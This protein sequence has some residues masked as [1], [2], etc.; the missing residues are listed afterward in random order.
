MRWL[1]LLMNSVDRL[2]ARVLHQ[3][4]TGRINWSSLCNFISPLMEGAEAF[5]L[6][7][8]HILS[9]GIRFLLFLIVFLI[10]VW[11]LLVGF[12]AAAWKLLSCR[13]LSILVSYWCMGSITVEFPLS[14]RVIMAL[15]S[16]SLVRID[17]IHLASGC[18]LWV[19]FC[20]WACLYGWL[21]HSLTIL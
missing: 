8:F 13:N 18:V 7:Y 1:I 17:F 21:L 9:L 2:Y 16:Y 15:F 5:M 3:F 11:N 6:M 10:W 20:C 4:T 14:A 19:G 12:V